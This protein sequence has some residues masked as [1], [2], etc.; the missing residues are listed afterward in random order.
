MNIRING[1]VAPGY[2]SLKQLYEYN[3]NTLAERNTQLCIFVGEECVV[4]LWASAIDDTAFSADSLINVWSSGKS[5]EPILFGMLIDRGLLDLN[6]P[7][8]DY[9]PEFGAHGKGNLTVADLMRHEAGLAAFDQTI[10]AEQ[11]Q[12]IAIKQ[13]AIG[14]IIE[15]QTSKFR[16]GE[17]SQREYHAVTRGWVANE[18]FRRIEPRGLTM[19][20]FLR[21][22]VS[23][24]LNADVYIGLHDVELKR[25]SKVKILSFRYQFLQ[26][27]IPRIF[28]RK[29]EHN[30]LQ[31]IIRI[32]QLLPGLSNSTTRGAPAPITGMN[33]LEIL[34]TQLISTG[35]I[36]SAGANCSARGLAKLAAVMANGG[37]FKGY[38]LMGDRAYAAL[39]DGAIRRNML[40]M[41][42]AFTQGGLAAFAQYGAKDKA[43]DKGLNYGREGFY[44]WMGLGGS[45]F[46]WHPQHRIG[47]GYAPT[48][49][50]VLDLVNERGKAYQIEVVRC[51]EN[52]S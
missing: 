42:V 4:D 1:T 32:C 50:N 25:V 23:T 16:E 20:E 30:L 39:H 11:L 37:S 3:M 13:N 19:G 34:N 48:S 18:I 7:I 22:E 35:E 52:L 6:K 8:S 47:F 26:S 27:L 5:L 38:K 12:T 10:E 17:N 36:P 2:E 45:I 31:I 14:V 43:F 15:R 49:L 40:A 29:I 33:N 21:E 46:Q 44:G 41:S 28:G 51:V 24:P 9:W